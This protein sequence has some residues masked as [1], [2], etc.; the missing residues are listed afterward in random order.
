MKKSTSLIIAFALQIAF[1]LNVK[2]S[3][4]YWVSG[5]GNWNDFGN[6]WATTSGGL[7]FHTTV[8]SLNDNVFFDANSFSGYDTVYVNLTTIYCKTM[9]WS[10]AGFNPAFYI[11]PN[12]NYN[13]NIYG[14]LI[15]SDPLTWN[16]HGAIGF[17]STTTGNIFKTANTKF[18]NCTFMIDGAGSEW[19]LE[20]TLFGH[21]ANW[22]S[23]VINNGTFVS[24]NNYFSTIEQINIGPAV[25]MADFGS[26]E[27]HCYTLN[28]DQTAAVNFS[29][30]IIYSN[31]IYSENN[32]FNKIYSHY[33][34][35]DNNTIKYLANLPYS[36]GGSSISGMSNSVDMAFL[37]S[38]DNIFSSNLQSNY[39]RN[40][41]ILPH[42]GLYAGLHTNCIFDTLFLDC[43]GQTVKFWAQDTFWVNNLFT[44]NIQAALPISLFGSD[45]SKATIIV[46]SGSVCFDYMYVENL[47]ATG[48][49]IFFAGANSVDFGHNA[50]WT[51]SSCTPAI[52]NV[53]PGDANYDLICDNFDLLNIGIAF[54]ETGPARPG[55]SLSWVA[56]PE[57]DWNSQFI[58]MINVK[59]ADCDGNG[60]VNA[61]DT[62]AVSQNYGLTHPFRLGSPNNTV[63][64]G[65]PL[66]F[67]ASGISFS[68][69]ST[70]SIPIKLGTS[71]NP[72]NVY[73]IAFTVN[74]DPAM[75][76]TGSMYIDYSGSM[77]GVPPDYITLEKDFSST[78]NFDAAICRTNHIDTISDGIVATLHFNVSNT[79]T[80]L[81]IL[82]FADV[83]AVLS[84]GMEV[85]VSP[86]TLSVPTGINEITSSDDYLAYPNPAADY[87]YFSNG[88][89]QKTIVRVYDGTG[90]SVIKLITEDNKVYLGNLSKGIYTILFSDKK[91]NIRDSKR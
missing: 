63:L 61:A 72:I 14:S 26:S 49:A 29:S 76:Q 43:P 21:S 88:N 65:P 79:A 91:S 64:S 22:C 62:I 82:S 39:F 1:C 70:V 53:W 36:Q 15:L 24:N 13:L 90:R 34:E 17:H 33:L 48:G 41:T 40:A 69:G 57:A 50:G 9:D 8:P 31:Q 27:I 84:Y 52:S 77:I 73:G 47:E 38:V 42:I 5:T 44:A 6:H 59:H 78:G 23:L 56:Q 11:A 2:A 46:P 20:D 25:V 12:L 86:Q 83:K 60:V 37:V 4:Y 3:D 32:N 45:T 66:Y 28:I 87:L 80:G 75:V 16:F 81:F 7:V 10:N 30:S 89:R 54:N 68:P 35:G 19:S 58:N 55:A 74:Y 51:W 85:A 18:T 67:D 71:N